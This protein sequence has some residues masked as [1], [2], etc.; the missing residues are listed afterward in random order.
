MFK[1]TTTHAI[2]IGLT[3]AETDGL[4]K[5][6]RSSLTDLRIKHPLYICLAIADGAAA[7]TNAWRM[8]HDVALFT[9]IKETQNDEWLGG[10]T[11]TASIQLQ[12]LD[13]PRLIRRLT[14]L[15]LSTAG[16]SSF[17]ETQIRILTFLEEI[18]TKPPPA[19]STWL[20]QKH[21]TEPVS[22][23]EYF[24]FLRQELLSA[25][26]QN[27]YFRDAALALIQTVYNLIAQRD[28]NLNLHIASLAS[29]DSSDMRVIAGV[30]LVFLPPTF[31]AVSLTLRA[32]I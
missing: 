16:A 25:Q 19:F 26:Q 15:S 14:S 31:T 18:S 27:K 6:I 23:T 9:A 29:R 11:D 17:V 22:I 10:E 21:G 20:A 2:C 30:T 1:S 28:T 3:T 32:K 8:D 5:R 4:I 12:Q 13:F 7:A 24:A